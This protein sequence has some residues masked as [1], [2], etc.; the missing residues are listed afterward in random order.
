EPGRVPKL[1][2]M[3]ITLWEPF[4]ETV[5]TEIILFQEWRQL[6]KHDTDERFQRSDSS[7]ISADGA[8]QVRELL[9]VCDEPAAFDRVHKS[10]RRFLPPAFDHVRRW[11]PIKCQIDFDSRKLSGI[12]FKLPV[13]GKISGIKVFLPAFVRPTT[14][15][16]IDASHA[17][18]SPRR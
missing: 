10:L 2:R 11:Q 4:E 6:P 15:A 7:K 14:G 18:S 1:D 16:D 8:I 5:E 12:E 13:P 3:T 9:H 17:N